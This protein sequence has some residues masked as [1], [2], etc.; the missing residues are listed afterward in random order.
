MNAVLL[1]TGAIVFIGFLI[2][3]YR[4][5]VRIAVSL[6][7]TLVTLVIVTLA[8]PYV[9]D[10]LVKYTP[11]D[12]AIEN[13]IGNKIAGTAVSIVKGE[14]QGGMSEENVR[15]VLNA[16][17]ITEEQLNGYGIS[18]GDIAAGKVSGDELAEHGISN[19]IL[20]GLKVGGKPKEEI[21]DTEIPRDVQVAAIENADLPQLFKTLLSVNNNNEIYERLGA[22]T[23]AQYVGM[24]LSKLIIKVV[25]FLCTFLLVIIVLRAIVFALDVVSELPVL[26]FI[27]RIMGGLVGVVCALFVIWVL[28]AVV[29]LLYAT[30]PG[31]EI[32]DMIQAEE[33]TK[34]LYH[35]NPIMRLATKF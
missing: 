2:G 22:E 35:Y 24:F 7:T 29:T 4:G 23:F 18:I 31:K 11:V 5:A 32:Y 9:A 15:K 10:L 28:F 30:A 25:A 13:Q 14:E 21:E 34:M 17:G 19:S 20:D 6:L 3:V 8:T 33:I 1:T 27:N 26:G 12:E 16:A